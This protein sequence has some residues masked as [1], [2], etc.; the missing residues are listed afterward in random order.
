MVN[1]T[2]RGRVNVGREKGR[3]N[4]L[5]KDQHLRKK[6]CQQGR[7]RINLR[8]RSKIERTRPCGTQGENVLKEGIANKSESC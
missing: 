4:I 5:K 2:T 7:I 3:G 6:R 1:E 8:G